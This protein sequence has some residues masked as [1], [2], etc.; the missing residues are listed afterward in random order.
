M[1]LPFFK[2]FGQAGTDSLIINNSKGEIK[3]YRNGV[4]MT[5]ND[6]IS[7]FK[8]NPT[9]LKEMKIAR[10]DYKTGVFFSYLGGFVFGFCLGSAMSGEKVDYTWWWTLGVSAA[11]GGSGII[12]YNSGIKHHRKA[13]GIYNSSSSTTGSNNF[14]ILKFGLTSN[15]IGLKYSF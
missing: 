8:N 5:T 7:L 10:A 11:I 15:G 6:F 13:I 12:I 1:L 2:S 9:A 3:C 14:Q 4:L